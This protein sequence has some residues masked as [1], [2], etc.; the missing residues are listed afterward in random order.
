MQSAEPSR[1]PRPHEPLDPR[2]KRRGQDE[3]EEDECE[4]EL[5]LPERECDGDDRNDDQG[6]EGGALGCFFHNQ[7][8]FAVWRKPQT[9]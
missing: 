8:S 4:D 7:G 5:Q 6:R 1:D 2:A 3:G 9:R